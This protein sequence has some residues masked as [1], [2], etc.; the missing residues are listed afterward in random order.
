MPF[1]SEKGLE[2]EN[3][4]TDNGKEFCGSEGHPY[5]IYLDLNEIGHRTT[6]VRRQQKD[7]FV[8]RFTGWRYW[9][10]SSG[11]PFREKLYES[12]E[13]LQQD[14]DEWLI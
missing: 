12:L 9:T 6:K 14:L 3:V 8:E 13:A 11:R 7:G 1:Y 5:R 2:V 4:L 10:S